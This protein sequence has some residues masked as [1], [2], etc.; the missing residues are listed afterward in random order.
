MALS[1]EF[2]RLLKRREKLQDD[3]VD[4]FDTRLESFAENAARRLAAALKVDPDSIFE[5]SGTDGVRVG[6]TDFE[7]R[8]S[9]LSGPERIT[10]AVMAAEL[11]EVEDFVAAAG[12]D[13]ARGAL[14]RTVPE[15]A[16][17]AEL[18]FDAQGVEGAIGSLDTVAA[19]ALIGNYINNNLD[20]AIRRSVD[21]AAAVRIQ[22]A[23][24]ANLGLRN[25]SEIAFDIAER[26]LS[27]I[28]T[29]LT[30]ARTR[31]A[32]AD[33]FVQETVRR[34]VDPDGEK[35]V[36]AY[37][38]PFGPPNVIRPFCNHLVGKY[39][40]VK[41]FNLANNAQTGTHPRISG[42]GYNCRHMVQPLANNKEY[43]DGLAEDGP[44]GRGL[45]KGTKQD[46]LT[47]NALAVSARRRNGRKGRKR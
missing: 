25:P 45:V 39:F 8:I 19:E 22:Q 38:G 12:L 24:S 47:A 31:M 3:A 10:A 27:S 44:E 34:S 29:A 33:R 7:R 23:L 18:T 15:L 5:R 9:E 6:A 17:L 13:S 26:E 43:L 35:F 14:R 11:A 40:S 36:L 20:S 16:G 42:G 4:A 46:I 21:G 37:I 2:K 30:E 1:G 41:D 32:E 28:P